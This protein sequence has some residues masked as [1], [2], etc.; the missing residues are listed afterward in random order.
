MNPVRFA[1]T[2]VFAALLPRSGAGVPPVSFRPAG[3]PQRLAL[4]LSVNDHTS[5]YI[6]IGIRFPE[7]SGVFVA[8]E[9]SELE[10]F[11]ER[12][13]NIGLVRG[14]IGWKRGKNRTPG[15]S[16]EV[17]VGSACPKKEIGSPL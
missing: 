13:V 2:H 16:G 7:E 4:P 15:R 9:R 14:Q 11:F 17:V 8:T 5:E 6:I 1:E 3:V 12:P 10:V